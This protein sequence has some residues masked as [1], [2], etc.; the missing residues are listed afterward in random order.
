MS[1]LMAVLSCDGEETRIVGGAVRNSLLGLPVNDIDMATTAL[2]EE[3]LRRAKAADLRAI[4]TGIEHG[5]ITVIA[6][7]CPVEVTTLRRDM[8]TDGRHA[9]VAF[10]RDFREDALRRDF[11]VNA[12]MLDAGGQLHDEVGGLADLAEGRIRFIGEAHERITEDALRIL[13]FYRF[14][15]AYGHGLP[16]A[17]GRSACI[18]GRAGMERLSAERIRA[19][20]L[21]LVIAK[22][23]APALTAMADDGLLLAVLGGVAHLKRLERVVQ[24]DEAASVD[25]IARLALLAISTREDALRLREG[26]RLSNSELAML[27]G[28]GAAREALHGDALPKLAHLRRLADAHGLPEVLLALSVLVSRNQSAE[29]ADLGNQLRATPELLLSGRDL[30][31]R[32]VAPGESMGALLAALRDQWIEAGCPAAI[33]EQSALLD[34][35]LAAHQ[36]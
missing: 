1:Q 9:V 2:P 22:G 3:T 8:E 33:D 16:D 11:T 32:G 31:D 20:L 12:L 34:A 4:P 26:L 29:L 30:I 18:S 27:H 17:E 35:L 21:K 6:E 13:R 15:A 25:P 7:G 23:A 24:A 36:S 14:H 28:F 5:T 19:E 10:G